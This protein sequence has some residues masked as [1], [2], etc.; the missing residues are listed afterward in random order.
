MYKETQVQDSQYPWRKRQADSTKGVKF[1]LEIILEHYF[2]SACLVNSVSPIT[3]GWPKSQV[4]LSD[5]MGKTRHFWPTQYFFK[6]KYFSTGTIISTFP[7]RKLIQTYKISDILSLIFKCLGMDKTQGFLSGTSG[8]EPAC[9]CRRHKG[10]GFNPWVRKIPWRRAWQPTPVFLPGESHGRRSP[11][12]NSPW[13][14][15]ESDMTEVTQHS[16]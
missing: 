16:T 12:Y 4:L 5:G 6:H 15:K 10:R 13:P 11:E 8:K 3:L 2:P 9:Q 7:Y 14:H 1:F